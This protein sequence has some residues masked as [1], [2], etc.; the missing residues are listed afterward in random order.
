MP[1][2]PVY[3][4]IIVQLADAATT[5]V[6]FIAAYYLWLLLP[7]ASGATAGPKIDLD[8][9]HFILMAMSAVAWVMIFNFLGAYSYQR[10]T[11]FTTEIK[12]ILKTVFWGLLSVMGLVFLLRSTYVPRTFVALFSLANLV[13]LILEKFLLF[14]TARIIR[15]R[16]RNRKT[17]LVVGTGNQARR[18]VEAIQRHFCWGLDIVG[19]L[20][21][22]KDRV[23]RELFGKKILGTT[24]DILPVLHHYP[25]D[26]VIAT[27]ST[28]RLGEV[29]EV[30]EVCEREGVP[31]RIISDFLGKIAKR[32]RADVIYGLPII[33]I[34]YIPHNQFALA[35]KRAMDIVISS[36]A[37]MALT[38]HILII[39]A[40][41]KLTSPGPVFYDWYVVGFNKKPFKSWKF[42]TMV[43]GAD[44]IKDQLAHLNEMQGPVFKIANDPRVTPV[45]RFLR[46]Y[47]FDELPQLWSV[48]KGDMSLVGPRPAGPHE[49]A[50][51]ESWQR[52]K[53]SIKPGITCLWQVSG[54]NSISN[55]NDWAKMDLAYIDN[56]SL[57]LDCK[58]LLR[59]IPA[60]IS[61]KGAS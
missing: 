60:I 56:W 1:W 26:E 48:F 43:V 18:F 10:F 22:G 42:R 4:R 30:L 47:S 57:W 13:L 15:S 24:H 25:V 16:G 55:F 21:V 41:I 52:R 11:S 29:R 17:V 31:V 23:G 36:L 9:S 45:G 14:Y 50:R 6:S 8:P 2:R 19:F 61:G 34:S 46:K 39:A 51:Y 27:V 54:R 32:F 38:P 20:D 53:L 12:I 28:R 35:V 3:H 59:T 5:L 37:L 7:L 58:I 33:S 40:A 49:L 44:Q